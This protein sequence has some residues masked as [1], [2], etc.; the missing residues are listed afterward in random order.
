MACSVLPKWS[1]SARYVVVR[2]SLEAWVG[3]LEAA[4]PL[5]KRLE[6]VEQLAE[7]R[8]SLQPFPAKPPQKRWVE[9]EPEWFRV[10][11]WRRWVRDTAQVPGV[12]FVVLLLFPVLQLLVSEGLRDGP[13]EWDGA[14]VAEAKLSQ[15]LGQLLD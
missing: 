12:L 15:Q 6:D 14:E 8:R 5:L 1:W 3:D 2:E 4:E 10:L 7:D 13:Q 9:P 11:R